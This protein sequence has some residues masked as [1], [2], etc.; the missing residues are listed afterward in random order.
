MGG[1]EHSQVWDVFGHALWSSLRRYEAGRNGLVPT[2]FAY[3]FTTEKLR[4]YQKLAH[5]RGSLPGTR[6]VAAR[7]GQG[8]P[9]L[10]ERRKLCL[11]LQIVEQSGFVHT[12]TTEGYSVF[13]LV[14]S[15]MLD[16]SLQSLTL[17]PYRTSW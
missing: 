3:N 10:I 11:M 4:R 2:F 13:S 17:N 15:A 12:M 14:F 1:R 5:I 8:F 9:T 16:C 6:T 7:Q